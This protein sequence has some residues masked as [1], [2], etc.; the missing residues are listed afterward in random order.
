MASQDH[1]TSLE[2]I[3]SSEYYPKQEMIVDDETLQVPFPCLC[4]EGVRY[5]GRTADGIIALS[6]YRIVVCFKDSFINVPLGLI[7]IIECRDIF[8]LMIYCKDSRII[9]C[10]FPTNDG[11]LE[12]YKRLSYSLTTPRELNKVFA[13]AFYA[14]CMENVYDQSAVDDLDTTCPYQSGENVPNIFDKEV[15]RLGFDLKGPAWRIT[16]ANEDYK[17]CRTYPKCHIVPKKIGDEVL[18]DVAGFRSSRRIPSVVWRDKKSGAVIARCSQPEVGWLGWRRTEDENFLQ[19]IATACALNPGVDTCQAAESF[20]NVPNGHVENGA[21]SEPQPKK[22]LIVDARSYAAAV[23]N[24]AKGGGYECPEYY[25]NCEIQFMSLANIHAIRKSFMAI[26]TLCMGG[27]EQPNWFSLL[28]NS[29]WL[30]HIAGLMKSAIIV[31]NAIDKDGRPV[32]VHCSDGWDRTPQIVALAELMLDPYYRTLEGF[33]VL[34]EREWCEFGHKFADRCG[35]GINSDDGNERCPVFLQF[36]DCVH[37]LIR[38]FPCAFEYNEAFLVK[39]VQHTYSCLFGT[40]L[41]NSARERAAENIKCVTFSVWTLLK[42]DCWK[43]KNYLYVKHDEVLRPVCHVRNMQLWNAIYLA[44]TSPMTDRVQDETDGGTQGIEEEEQKR[45]EQMPLSKTRSCDNIVAALEHATMLTRTS[46]DPNMSSDLHH[47]PKYLLQAEA[48]TTL[49]KRVELNLPME[50][51][52][53]DN[54]P[55]SETIDEA[56]D[57]LLNG[58]CEGESSDGEEKK[59]EE[60]SATESDGDYENSNGMNR[61]VEDNANSAKSDEEL[62]NGEANDLNMCNGH[63]TTDQTICDNSSETDAL[64][65]I[66]S[67]TDTLTEESTL[68]GSKSKTDNTA[69]ENDLASQQ[70]RSN[71]NISR[72]HMNGD[73]MN[74]HVNGDSQEEL[75]NRLREEQEVYASISTSTTDIS[76]SH[77]RI[78]LNEKFLFNGQSMRINDLTLSLTS[79]V[80]EPAAKISRGTS[81]DTRN[82]SSK[83]STSGSDSEQSTPNMSRTPSSTCPPT[84]SADVKLSEP[85]F[86]NR[87]AN[88]LARR[89]DVDGL[90]LQVDPVQV[91]LH[92]KEQDHRHRVAK[93]ERQLQAAK[94]ALYQYASGC[95]GAGKHMNGDARDEES[96]LP[97]SIGSGDLTS[98]GNC[99]NTA[100]D[101]SWEAIEEKDARM[102]LWVPDHAATHCAG[103]QSE[104][105]VVRRKH[106]CRNCGRIFCATCADYFIA[107]PQQQLID[108][109]RV[110]RSCY[111]TI[112]SSLS[113]ETKSDTAAPLDTTLCAA[114]AA[115]A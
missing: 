95:N 33:Q 1:E 15:D 7:E 114:A 102:T 108:P 20:N 45:Q 48:E 53:Y 77:V 106:H 68:A 105:W 23:A 31:V 86:A 28:D 30:H 29:K 52:K 110:C 82:G 60:S 17:L 43:M 81:T 87:G 5:L 3:H 18:E 64:Q 2:H 50:K 71:N 38:Q 26:R 78:N 88:L 25:P 65:S 42:H 99:S 75:E 19:A 55:S 34:V 12:W 8:F 72:I 100:S 76:D 115:E 90:T 101:L 58:H 74:G 32:L 104:F 69:E 37:Q 96:S 70:S 47:D 21:P 62:M 36:L 10:T 54:V 83:S 57:G 97:D 109:V 89:L 13:F 27:A 111:K 56:R 24:R 14:W 4:G 84:P 39:L 91:R 112:S 51:V 35:S 49:D 103:C 93:L 107:I 98:L 6:N 16:Y 113:L 63:D 79:P 11:C 61:T 92:Q 80:V 9:R 46:S 94:V 67:S 44:N 22:L 73:V 85:G 40:F 59:S 66:T 41:C